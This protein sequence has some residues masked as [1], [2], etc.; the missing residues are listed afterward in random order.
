MSET[1]KYLTS[2][3]KMKDLKEVD[4][5]L[6]IKVKKFSRGYALCQSHYIEKMLLKFQHL[7]IKEVSTPYDSA[8][9][10]IK[11][12][13]RAVTQLEY[14]SVIGSLMYAIHCTRPDISFAICKLFR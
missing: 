10:L 9:K 6:G 12:S 1:K 13:G 2:K 7:R 11:N 4:T 5:I 14:T 3:F 8:F